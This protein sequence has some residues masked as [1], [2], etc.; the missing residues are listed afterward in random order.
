MEFTD[1]P[2]F[3]IA[4][5]TDW[6]AAG[7][8]GSDVTLRTSEALN[9]EALSLKDSRVADNERKLT[10]KSTKEQEASLLAALSRSPSSFEEN[11]KLGELYLREDKYGDSASFLQKAF[12]IDPKN[13]ANEIELAQAC[14]AAGDLSHAREHVQRIMETSVGAVAHRLAAELD[15]KSGDP[16][17]AVHE[18]ERAVSID[19]SE[20]NYFEWG[21]ELLVHR[22]VWQ[23]KEIFEKGTRAYPRSVRMLTALGAALFGGALY[24]DAARRLC[25]ASDLSRDDPEPYLLMGKVAIAAPAPVACIPDRLQRFVQYQPDNSRANFYLA[26]AIWKR[27]GQTADEATMQNVN[28]MLLKAVAIDPKFSDPYVQLGNLE[29]LHSRF[30]KAIDFYS[31]AVQADPESAEAHYRLGMAY[32]RLGEREQAKREFELHEAIEKRQAAA[33]DRERR[34]VKQFIVEVPD[35][36]VRPA[37]Q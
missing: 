5:V 30:A 16:L 34:E 23:A 7:G 35:K 9:R 4:G 18:Y 28:S 26:M 14:L 11:H 31:Q 13:S 22:A 10:A 37:A 8:H 36:P 25:E 3:T 21:S 33:V 12:E 29:Y 6:T 1:S 32:D 17:A 15:E 19:P 2:N 20:Q 27:G 24:D